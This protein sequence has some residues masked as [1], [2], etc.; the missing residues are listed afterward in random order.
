VSKTGP[1]GAPLF[2]LRRDTK[3]QIPLLSYGSASALR[4]VLDHTLRQQISPPNLLVVNQNA[5]ANSVK[6][7]ILE[8]FGLG[9]LPRKLCEGEL[10]EGRLALAGGDEFVTALSVRL[11][12]ETENTKPTLHD[13]WRKMSASIA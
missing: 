13:F 7:M 8:G 5:L 10:A 1:D 9:W 6:A 12:R 11:Y 4:S 2:D 3:R